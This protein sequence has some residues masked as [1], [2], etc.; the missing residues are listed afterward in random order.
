MFVAILLPLYKPV[1]W[2]SFLLFIS[3]ISSI[4]V[5]ISFMSLLFDEMYDVFT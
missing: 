4:I 1:D 2:S 3:S 5:S